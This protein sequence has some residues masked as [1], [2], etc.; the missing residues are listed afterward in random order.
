MVE[1]KDEQKQ[2]TTA[3]APVPSKTTKDEPN[4]TS[5]AKTSESGSYEV[6]DGYEVVKVAT[7]KATQQGVSPISGTAPPKHTQFGQPG[8]NR[9]NNGGLPKYV[10]ELREELKGLLDPN[11]TMGDYKDIVENGETDSGLR[12][13]FAEAITKKDTRT[14]IQLIDQA[15]G[16]PKESVDVTSQGESINP[17]TVR[18]IDERQKP[19][20][21]S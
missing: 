13:V 2:N 10:R 5:S 11:L 17:P 1:N 8:G 21:E 16:K 20:E 15:W 6:V 4:T 7:A 3:Q 12:A 9:R 19:K 18:I 14:I